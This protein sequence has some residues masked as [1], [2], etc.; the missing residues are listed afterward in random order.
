MFNEFSNFE[1]YLKVL[2]GFT[3]L[4]IAFGKLREIF[5]S[6][7]RKEEI[8]IDLEIIAR[9][10]GI[11]KNLSVELERKI[12]S[13][14]ERAFQE[15]N[16]NL[17]NFFTGLAVFIGFGFWTIDILNKSNGFNGW[18]IVTIFFSLIGLVLIIN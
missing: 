17:T 11:N 18:M 6:I 12:I 2:L 15:K 16:D 8:K 14:I 10:K 4:I 1:I 13:K 3:G 7:K 5:A 9:L